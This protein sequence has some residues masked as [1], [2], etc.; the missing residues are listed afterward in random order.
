[1]VPKSSA[2]VPGAL[3]VESIA[4]MA[5]HLEMTKYRSE[6]DMGYKKLSGHLL[7]IQEA[8]TKV[9]VNWD[10]EEWKHHSMPLKIYLMEYILTK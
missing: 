3:D 10:E 6:I 1:M 7:I 8:Q 9:R 4:I 5:N 2:V